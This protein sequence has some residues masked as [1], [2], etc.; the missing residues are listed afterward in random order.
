[1]ILVVKIFAVKSRSVGY[2]GPP[3]TF[4]HRAVRADPEL[5][6][7]A[8]QPFPD[9][10]T[11]FEA[12]AR[13][14]VGQAVIAW[15]NSLAGPVPGAMDLLAEADGQV[16]VWRDL[17]MP[18]RLCLWGRRGARLA[19]ISTVMSH[20]HAL[21][22][23]AGWVQAMLPAAVCTPTSSTA[24]ALGLVVADRSGG[25]AAAAPQGVP[26]ADSAMVVLARDI[27]D[28]ADAETRFIVI[29]PEPAPPRDPCR[30]VLSCSAG[31][32]PA[33]GVGPLLATVFNAFSGEGA[34]P[35]WLGTRPARPSVGDLRLVLECRGEPGSSRLRT[36]FARLAGGGVRAQVLGVLA[37]AEAKRVGHAG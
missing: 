19:D 2:L 14:R 20:P 28:V 12:V 5:A 26:A 11:I 6:V 8:H 31:Q 15:D 25:T 17:V 3:G 32:V 18:V 13:R 36:A 30:T 27:S 16:Q 10:G 7:A 29:G 37:G 1:M 21:A 34:V 35:L 4:T 33:A 9:M 24:A 22:Q 23:C